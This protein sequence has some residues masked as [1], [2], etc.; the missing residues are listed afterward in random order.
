MADEP[1]A[2]TWEELL[3]LWENTGQLP[4]EPEEVEVPELPADW[5]QP[6][7]PTVDPTLTEEELLALQQEWAEFAKTLWKGVEWLSLAPHAV[8]QWAGFKD[9][10]STLKFPGL[11]SLTIFE[12]D[13]DVPQWRNEVYGKREMY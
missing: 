5:P 3:E 12:D 6:D 4:T 11:P 8:N 1:K 9:F 13:E 2:P 10:I 7:V